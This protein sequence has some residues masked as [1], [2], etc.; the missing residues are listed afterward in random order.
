MFD[1]MY[2]LMTLF[3]LQEDE[4]DCLLAL[5]YLARSGVCTI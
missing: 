2:K 1:V 5:K 3:F 4:A